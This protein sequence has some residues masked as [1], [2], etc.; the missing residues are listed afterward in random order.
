MT[1]ADTQ[2]KILE[3]VK[4]IVDERIGKSSG[5]TIQ[6]GTVAEEPAGYKCIVNIQGTEKTCT[7]P[8]HL[9]DWISKDDIVYVSDIYG[10]GS[11]LVVTGSS[12]ST[13]GQTL[14]INDEEKGRLVSGVTKFED[15]ENTLTDNQLIVKQ[16]EGT[17]W[18]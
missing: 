1:V 14:V 10:T 7:L 8:E 16:K 6:V 2:N 11:D 9:H 17:I 3:A 13:R 4:T 15:D 12:G 5:P 18:R